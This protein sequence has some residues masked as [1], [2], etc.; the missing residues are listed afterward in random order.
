M[1]TVTIA[2]AAVLSI[3]G[4]ALMA[5]RHNSGKQ[6]GTDEAPSSISHLEESHQ[7]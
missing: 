4:A 2:L 6:A 5:H 3:T 7:S 1:A